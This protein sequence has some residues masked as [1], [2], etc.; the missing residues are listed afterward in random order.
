MLAQM[1]CSH[2]IYQVH[3][4]LE[5]H[6][7]KEY[8][9]GLHDSTKEAVRQTYEREVNDCITTLRELLLLPEHCDFPW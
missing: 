9:E 5:M 1:F 6:W 2:L 4:A 7:Q 3:D 8:A